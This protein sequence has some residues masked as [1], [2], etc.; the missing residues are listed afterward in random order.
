MPM[1]LPHRA[2]TQSAVRRSTGSGVVLALLLLSAPAV[3]AGAAAESY[4][5]DRVLLND[6]MSRTVTTGWGSSTSG[7]PYSSP[8]TPSFSMADGTGLVRLEPGRIKTIT[9]SIEPVLNARVRADVSL[10]TLPGTGNGIYSTFQLR[11]AG[12]SSY[13]ATLRLTPDAGAIMEVSRYN[14]STQRKVL[15]GAPVQ[16]P[17]AAAAQE[18]LRFEFQ[19]S[20]TD[21]VVLKARAWPADEPAPVWQRT[22]LDTT[23]LRLTTPG[24]TAIDNYLSSSSQASTVR[25]DNLLVRE[26]MPALPVAPVQ[27]PAPAPVQPPAPAPAPV[28]PPAPAP[29]P[30]PPSSGF[31]PGWGEPTW[32]DE[33]DGS[34]AKWNVRDGES[35]SYDKAR[36]LARNVTT[37]G[38]Y[39]NITA[40]R[41]D[42]AGR[43][44]TTG[45]LDTNNRYEQQ[46]GRWEM[47]AQIPTI[48]GQSRGVWPAFWLRNN[49]VGE[50]DI[51]E[52][53]GDPFTNPTRIGTSTMTAHSSTLGGG[54]RAAFNWE[55]LA[56]STEHS[57]LAFHTWAVEYT[58]TELRGYFDGK[59]VITMTKAKY[60][61]L[62]GSTFTT[63]FEMRLNLQIGSPYHGYPVA[64]SYA[65]T[66]MPAT[67]KVDYVRAWKF[68]Q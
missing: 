23:D 33:F 15:I 12:G 43:A 29:V 53:W 40:K 24:L 1:R 35:L 66:K 2:R 8:H 56:G 49:T 16:L 13:Q 11:A 14:A 5:P 32:R 3:P 38:G 21:P 30:A 52:A 31:M 62:W 57:A 18:A 68:K 61:W 19:V 47:R 4:V 64:P 51:M 45:Y 37:S 25:W 20:G 22:E 42:V 60:P 26:L 54:Q 46:Y 17:Q 36:I 65:D 10:D 34:T 41:E 63:P 44:F 28:Q 48:P 58:P 6:T 59:Q 27:P 67:F 9:S 7:I 39:L 55:G 50:I